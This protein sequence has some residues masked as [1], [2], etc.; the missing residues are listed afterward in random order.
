VQHPTFVLKAPNLLGVLLEVVLGIIPLLNAV[1]RLVAR[2]A[3]ARATMLRPYAHKPRRIAPEMV[4]NLLDGF[5][6][7]HNHA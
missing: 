6:A 7:P 1:H 5:G 3:R 2:N 4:S